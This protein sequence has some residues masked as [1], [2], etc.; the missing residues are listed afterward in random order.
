MLYSQ[1]GKTNNV[2][3]SVEES[4]KFSEE[5]INEAVVAVKRKFRE[6]QGCELTDLWYSEK[7]PNEFVEGYMKYG[8]GST[9]GIKEENVIVL[10]SNFDVNSKGGDGSFEPNSTYSDWN[11]ILVRDHDSGKWRVDDWGY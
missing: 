8:K 4:T 5:E 3:V 7:K 1:S 11:W 2:E 9:N 6:F 10:L